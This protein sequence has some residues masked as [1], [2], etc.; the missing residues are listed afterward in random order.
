MKRLIPVLS[1]LLLVSASYAQQPFSVNVKRTSSIT[2]SGGKI[3]LFFL[4]KEVA[5]IKPNA[6]FT[7]N[8]ELPSDSIIPLSFKLKLGRPTRFFLYPN[9]TFNYSL[10]TKAGSFGISVRD[11]SEYPGLTPAGSVNQGKKG[12]LPKGVSVNKRN[13]AVSYI[14]EKTLKSDEIRQQWARQGGKLVGRSLSYVFT[15]SHMLLADP[16][17]E[18]TVV[19]AGWNFTQN[20]YNLKI[21][22][23]KPGIRSWNSL[24]Y[25]SAFSANV[26]MTQ[27]KL[28][29]EPSLEA[30]EFTSGGLL[31]M[32][33]GNI[34]Y[35]LGLGKFKSE[36][37]YRGVAIDLTYRPSLILFAGEGGSSSS[38]NYKGV[39][40][41][42]SRNNFSAYANRIAPK[43][44]SK[45]SLFLL[46]PLKDTP[47]TITFGYGLVWYR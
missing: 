28:D 39:G 30:S 44:K 42:I 16:K 11:L 22:E 34:G 41:D 33:S 36:T 15:Y 45:F 31:L 13:L 7:L 46:P 14:N 25:G 19:G 18:T 3:M 38:F 27:V 23:Y 40:I 17:T 5:R 20:L 1:A 47:L 32:M 37:N 26:F 12:A 8:G 9:S 21:P 43:A 35:T 24:I 29:P 10:E 6:T 4:D 2:G